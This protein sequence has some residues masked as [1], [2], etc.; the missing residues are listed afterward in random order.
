M[1]KLIVMPKLGLTMK[2]GKIVK[3]HKNEGDK[4]NSG[5]TLL[6]IATDKLTN[7]IEANESGYIRKLLANEGDMVPCLEPIAIIGDK[8][9]DISTLLSETN[10]KNEENEDSTKLTAKKEE[11]TEKKDE[12]KKVKASPVAKK[13]A[14]EKGIDITG[15]A[16]TGPNGRITKEDV[17]KYIENKD[18]VKASPM[19]EKAAKDLKVNLSDVN[20]QGRIM[21]QDVLDFSKQRNLAEAADP[22]DER[23]PM[24]QMRKV[25]SQRM[26]DSWKLSPAVTYDIK[27]DVTNLRRLKDELRDVQKLTYTDFL[28]KIASRALLEFPLVNC[29][30]DN[31]ELILRNYTNIGVA[32]AIDAGL[33][34]PVVKYAN[35]KGLKDISSEIKELA[36]KAKTNQLSSDDLT[37]GTFTITNL[38]MFGMDSFSPIINQPEVAILGVNAINEVPVL[39][40]GNLV[41]KPFM[42]LSL[43]AD[44]RAVD[45]AVAAQFLHRI[46]Q[47]IEKPGMLIL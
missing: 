16:G 25:I 33:V 10:V 32:V 3:W 6:E 5:E 14:K 4:I 36:F 20:K 35:V 11:I 42:K 28:V 8:N 1:A 40:N 23:I 47:Y 29:S 39:E 18:K 15:I 12:S 2:E 17:E 44:H 13:L 24:T 26:S 22:R 41:N 30:I 46:K 34:V 7:E 37:G 45:G 31:E 38:G 19:A 27:V 21:K 9:E 43:T